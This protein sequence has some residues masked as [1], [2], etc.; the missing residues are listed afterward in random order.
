[1]TIQTLQSLQ[2]SAT[3]IHQQH[4]CNHAYTTCQHT[5]L[6][7]F[8]VLNTLHPDPVLSDIKLNLLINNTTLVI[9]K[10]PLCQQMT[11]LTIYKAMYN[12]CNV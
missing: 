6:D 1:M 9:L 4:I 12:L 10:S 11:F 5:R 8:N 3:Y 7:Q 2:H